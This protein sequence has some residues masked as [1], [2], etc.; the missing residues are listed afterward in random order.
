MNKK[1]ACCVGTI[2]NVGFVDLEGGVVLL[3]EGEWEH[4]GTPSK[5]CETGSVETV[6]WSALVKSLEY[7]TFSL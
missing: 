7:P 6:V 5:K 3:V 2:V 4:D 1:Y